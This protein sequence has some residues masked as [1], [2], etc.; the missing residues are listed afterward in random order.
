V[1]R[2]RFRVPTRA[3]APSARSAR[4]RRGGGLTPSLAVQSREP[5]TPYAP[6]SPTPSR[7]MRARRCSEP[8]NTAD[9][10]A[11]SGRT[12]IAVQP[13][14]ALVATEACSP[15]AAV[16]RASRSAFAFAVPQLVGGKHCKLT[17]S[18]SV[19]YR[20]PLAALVGLE[21]QRSEIDAKTTEIRRRLRALPASNFVSAPVAGRKRIMSADARRRIATGQRRRWAA[22]KQ[23]KA[24]AQE[25]KRV[26]SAAARKRIAESTR[27]R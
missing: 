19:P 3:L 12:H 4:V 18:H 14:M 16:Q 27:K 24:E 25:P 5:C 10:L 7:S 22:A 17:R 15:A 1:R 2:Y 11:R 6:A 9:V 20:N 23:E 21:H 8:M 13:M 26:L